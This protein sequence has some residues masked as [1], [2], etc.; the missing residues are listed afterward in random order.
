VTSR[1]TCWALCVVQDD[2]SNIWQLRILETQFWNTLDPAQH[3]KPHILILTALSRKDKT[4][5]KIFLCKFFLPNMSQKWH[6]GQLAWFFGHR[7]PCSWMHSPSRHSAHT[8]GPLWGHPHYSQTGAFV[9][10]KILSL[11]KRPQPQS[12]LELPSTTHMVSLSSMLW[13][14]FE[15]GCSVVH[16]TAAS[17]WAHTAEQSLP[18]N[19]HLHS[20]CLANY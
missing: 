10:G 20:I 12:A 7:S 16:C 3:P 8:G 18:H 9:S 14:C 17:P 13:F 2:R 5:T 4:E 6:W 19:H 1:W 11:W 15:S